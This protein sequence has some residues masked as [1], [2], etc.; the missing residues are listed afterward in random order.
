[1]AEP[2]AINPQTGER[3]VFRGGQW[4]PAGSGGAPVTRVGLP[5][6]TVARQG[7][8]LGNTMANTANAV[9]NATGQG[10]DNTVKGA[11]VQPQIQGIVAGAD[12]TSAEAVLAAQAAARGGVSQEKFDKDIGRYNTASQL[13]RQLGQVEQRFER[14]F[15]DGGIGQS[16]REYLPNALSP[17]NQA[18]DQA[19]AGMKPLLYAL[20][21]KTDSNPA[22]SQ[23]VPYDQYV[24]QSGRLDASNADA[25]KRTR[26]LAQGVLAETE[27]SVRAKDTGFQQAV[28]LLSSDPSP[29][30]RKQFDEAAK[31]F[32]WP[33]TANQ[34][35]AG[36]K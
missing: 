30:R 21:P 12:K 1:M 31:K 16:L 34:I 18:F 22:A 5:T 11:T 9:A 27:Y 6:A 32:G 25:I 2:T 26:E 33:N 15:R 7:A 8:Q 3:I 13:L 29:V 10:I 24:P 17:E 19:S 36:R 23:L 35:L 28:Q 4:V 20:L 14:D